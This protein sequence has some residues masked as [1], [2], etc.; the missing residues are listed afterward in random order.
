MGKC[1]GSIDLRPGERAWTA[2]EAP[3]VVRPH[4]Y[5]VNPD[6]SVDKDDPRSHFE[7]AFFDMY[8]SDPCVDLVS[9]ARLDEGKIV[10][11]IGAKRELGT[12]RGGAMCIA[13]FEPA[14]V[15]ALIG[16]LQNA[17]KGPGEGS[18]V[19]GYRARVLLHTDGERH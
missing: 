9:V 4:A 19:H 5:A 3:V 18:I 2:E 12:E 7:P 17:L 11:G 6:G 1:K 10:V 13:F 14:G 16:L 8:A 15:E